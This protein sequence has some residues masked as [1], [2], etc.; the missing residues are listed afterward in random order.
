MLARYGWVFLVISC[1]PPAF[2]N[3][4]PDE[5]L[6]GKIAVIKPGKVAKF[7][8][9][10]AP[11]ALFALPTAANDPTIEGGVLRMFDT[12][13]GAG[14]ETYALPVQPSPYGWRALGTPPGSKGYKY[15]GAG[16][17][18][19]PCTVVLVKPTV[20]KAV[21]RG[22]GVAFT[23]PF[24]ADVGIVLTVGTDSKRYCATFGGVDIRNEATVVKRR[25]SPATACPVPPPPPP[26]PGSI[27]VDAVTGNDLNAGTMAAPKK[28]IQ[29]G[30]AAA[31]LTA[32]D[33]YVSKG[34]YVES[35]ML[36][37]G[38]S[39]L[40]GY[41]AAAGWTF[42]S[43]NLVT[44]V[45]GP[46]AVV[47]TGINMPTLL[48]HLRI[49]AASNAAAGGS[50]YG[51]YLASSTGLGVT[52]ATIVAGD[53]GNGALGVT[54]LPGANGGNGGQ[55]NPGCEDSSIFCS[56]CSRPAGGTAGTSSCGR[57]GGVGGMPGLGGSG[58]DPGGTGTIGT[59][60]GPGAPGESADG[61]EGSDGSPGANGASGSGGG[62]FGS[63]GPAGYFPADGTTG[64][65]GDHG[66]GGGGGGGGGG[67]TTDCDSYGSSGGGGGG[68]GCGGGAATGGGGGGG[69]FA[70]YL[71][72]STI[73]VTDS[74]LRSAAGGGGGDG[75]AGGA[76]GVGGLPGPG[77]P[78]GGSGQQ[79]DGGNGAA[80]GTGG[81]GG[82]GGDGGGGGGGPSVGV[83]CAGGSSLGL[84]AGNTYVIGAP[85]SG[86]A[87]PGVPGA[88]GYAAQT[89]GC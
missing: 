43:A 9:K 45:G 84:D 69:S 42:S 16:S 18:A 24:A 29:G 82:V 5:L 58:G 46:T 79:D 87:G 65:S 13:T 38:V 63:A 1:V 12:S 23:P 34:T 77:G 39:L 48:D 37:D 74:E 40:G 14:D 44:V 59:P 11:P 27:F 26:P 50:S 64:G 78:Y 52:N 2:A 17:V 41:D 55:G 72:D 75:G 49:E 35:L 61:T 21:C 66:N 70:I 57:T 53:G 31:T 54:G 85:G 15:H 88:T 80:G 68:G 30:I 7:V 8:A 25:L 20:V 60:G 62:S 71:F 32:T 47:G 6:P 67:G 81:D 36:A 10:P 33:V 4:E 28:T 73:A 86:G 89:N 76:R 22:A 83:V 51:L 56:S 3:D 19:D